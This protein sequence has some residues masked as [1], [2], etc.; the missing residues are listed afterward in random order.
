M[1]TPTDR[2]GAGRTRTRQ[3]G[4]PTPSLPHE[5]DE[6]DGSQTQGPRGD[7]APPRGVIRKA[8]E[9]LEAGRMDTDLRGTPGLPP[10]RS[11]EDER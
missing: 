8:W 10:S 6:S 2:R 7:D 5:R 1:L 3:Q 4:S 9:D 11:P